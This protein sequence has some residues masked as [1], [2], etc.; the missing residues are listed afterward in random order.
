MVDET[1]RCFNSHVR[2]RSNSHV[3][4]GVFI[5]DWQS[6]S[7]L[8]ACNNLRVT[9]NDRLCFCQ[10]SQSDRLRVSLRHAVEAAP[11]TKLLGKLGYTALKL[12]SC[13]FQLKEHWWFTSCCWRHAVWYFL[14]S[15][16]VWRLMSRQSLSH[17]AAIW[18]WVRCDAPGSTQR[19]YQSTLLVSSCS[20][21]WSLSTERPKHICQV[22]AIRQML[23]C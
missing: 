3:L 14:S 5:A 19:P 15:F 9:P 10:I 21:W 12:S 22:L 1:A 20:M 17:H 16:G 23:K 2:F 6:L 8:P 18:C 7:L 11:A 4:A 13:E